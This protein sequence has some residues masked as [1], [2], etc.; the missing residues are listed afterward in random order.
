MGVYRLVVCGPGD[1]AVVDAE[2]VEREVFLS[3]FGNTPDELAVEYGPYR[4]SSDFLLSVCPDGS[5][6]GVVRAVRPSPAGLKSLNDLPGTWGMT[7]EDALA[8]ESLDPGR[9]VDVATLAVAAGRR[10]REGDVFGSALLLRG[11]WLYLQAT[12]ADALVAVVH[13][14]VLAYL[15]SVGVALRPLAGLGSAEYLGSAGSTP[16]VGVTDELGE[17][18]AA[19]GDFGLM[20]TEGN[21]LEGVAVVE[22]RSTFPGP[23]PAT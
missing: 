5:V 4:E 22:V 12:R 13:D 10:R 11:I 20:V 6:A 9:V 19:A 21:G 7:G 15:N 8:V 18:M 14:E 16:V 17:G 3:E 1:E 23:L 2:R